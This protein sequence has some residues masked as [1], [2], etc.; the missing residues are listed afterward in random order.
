MW[1]DMRKRSTLYVNKQKHVS[2]VCS[3]V[4]V[5]IQMGWKLLMEMSEH[6]GL[7]YF[8]L[9]TYNMLLL[10]QFS[11]PNQFLLNKICL[12]KI[13]NIH[14]RV[15][16]Y[17]WLMLLFISPPGISSADLAKYAENFERDPKNLLA[18]NVCTRT[19]LLEVLRKRS[20]HEATHHVFTHKVVALVRCAHCQITHTHKKKMH[21][22]CYKIGEN[23][24]KCSLI[25]YCTFLS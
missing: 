10:W 9:S 4:A 16:H 15:F 25:N 11:P 19:D 6:T 21:G 22:H 3:N 2:R 14:W 24:P 18:Q 12:N 17:M 20:V 5:N 13:H 1:P 7:T 23:D 8:C